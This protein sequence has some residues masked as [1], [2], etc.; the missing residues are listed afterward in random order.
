MEGV[1]SSIDPAIS[2]VRLRI[3]SIDAIQGSIDAIKYC[4]DA[5]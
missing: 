2:Q 3:L 4:N 1:A 5:M